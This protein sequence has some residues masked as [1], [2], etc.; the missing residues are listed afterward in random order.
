MHQPS[1]APPSMGAPVALP[2]WAWGV[3]SRLVK[4]GGLILLAAMVA[5]VLYPA[6]QG[7]SP[8][9]DARTVG[10]SA[11]DI[12]GPELEGLLAHLATR[13]ETSVKSSGFDESRGLGAVF[14]AIRATSVGADRRLLDSCEVHV[15]KNVEVWR[16]R[17]TP[18]A[19]ATDVLMVVVLPSGK[20]LELTEGLTTR[21]EDGRKAVRDAGRSLAVMSRPVQRSK[22]GSDGSMGVVS[23][24]K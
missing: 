20:G 21:V 10:S 5:V 17:G 2:L 23:A 11:G 9:R 4:C 14:E 6:I 13:I 19:T 7:G 16:H 8:F 3:R 24:I 1:E 15:A 22:Q 12:E 18:K